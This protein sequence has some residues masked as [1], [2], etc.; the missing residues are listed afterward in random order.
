MLN[1]HV[2]TTVYKVSIM[3]IR[4]SRQSRRI[5]KKYRA[6]AARQGFKRE[7]RGSISKIWNIY[8]QPLTSSSDMSN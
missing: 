7:S 1:C 6:N 8:R 5:I 2:V 4:N 3:K